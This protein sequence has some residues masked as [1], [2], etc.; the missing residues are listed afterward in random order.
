[1][2]PILLFS[3]Y[4]RHTTQFVSVVSRLYQSKDIKKL[5]F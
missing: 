4:I 1:M 5:Y 3:Q 2:S